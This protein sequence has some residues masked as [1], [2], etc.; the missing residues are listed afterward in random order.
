MKTISVSSFYHLVNEFLQFVK[1]MCF[2]MKQVSKS[3]VRHN[4]GSMSND[5]S[6]Y[7]SKLTCM[8][9]LFTAI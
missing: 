6:N 7:D 8:T 1:G 5:L 3:M 2:F 4:D 9:C